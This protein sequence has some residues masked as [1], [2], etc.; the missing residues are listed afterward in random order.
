M[1]QTLQL[2]AFE[3]SIVGRKFDFFGDDVQHFDKD[4]SNLIKDTRILFIGAAGSI[5]MQT[6]LA[7]ARHEPKVIHVVDHNENGL[8]ELTRFIRAS[9]EDFNIGELL[10]MPMDYGSYVF[11][12]WFASQEDYDY[13]LNFSALKHVRS[14]KDPYSIL[15]MIETNVLK[16]SR[17]SKMLEKRQSLK[18]LFCISTDKA[19]N[20]SS[21]MGATKRLMEHAMFLDDINL[22]APL[23]ITSAR[24]A[25]VA[26][27]NGSLLQAW[28]FRLQNSQ[29]MACPMNCR[30]FFVSLSESGSLCML[31]S[32]LGEHKNIL[33]PKMKP[34]T[35]LVLLQDVVTTYL[36][37]EGLEPYFTQDEH[38]AKFKVEELAKQKKWPVLLTPLDTAGEKPYEEFVS[39]RETAVETKFASLDSVPYVPPVEDESFREFLEYFSALPDNPSLAR[40]ISIHAIKEKIGHVEQD[41]LE[42]HVVSKKSLDQRI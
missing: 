25:N 17:F 24:F 27:S 28:Q 8:A 42:T 20:S 15:G 6:L 35:H 36:K 32:M 22:P 41:F 14:E 16:L 21:M 3:Q 37:S 4:L 39:K 5:G 26:M 11:E 23:N 19:A 7:I 9:A 40:D 13:V 38:E 30:R 31:A 12:H 1:K 2:S 10:T 33:I 18:R 34:E 29:P